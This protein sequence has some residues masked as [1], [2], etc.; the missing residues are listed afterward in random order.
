MARLRTSYIDV[1]SRVRTEPPG[2][3][4]CGPQLYYP[5]V[6]PGSNNELLD[7]FKRDMFRLFGLPNWL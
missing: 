5:V 6:S 7:S 3:G 1:R 4:F 2:L